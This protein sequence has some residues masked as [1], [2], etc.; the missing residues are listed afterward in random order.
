MPPTRDDLP[1]DFTLSRVERRVL[2]QLVRTTR[3]ARL[4]RRA[5]ALL[6]F[7]EQDEVAAIA[8][9]LRVSRQTIYNWVTRFQQRASHPIAERVADGARTGRPLTA[10]GL[11]DS[12]IEEVIEGDPRDLGYAA[13]VWTAPLLRQYLEDV[14]QIVTSEDSVRRAIDRLGFR[15]KRPR[16]RLSLRPA[17]WRQAKGGFSEVSRDASARCC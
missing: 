14:R 1:L 4:L 10:G 7:A 8:A 11:I 12:Y 2:E 13:T 16:Y 3:D 9:R 6:W 15:W 17:T 5:Q